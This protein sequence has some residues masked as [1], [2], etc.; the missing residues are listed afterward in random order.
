MTELGRLAF[1]EQQA[2]EAYDAMYEAQSPSHGCRTTSV[3]RPSAQTDRAA[4]VLIGHL[5]FLL[6]TIYLSTS[7]LVASP[8]STSALRHPLERCIVWPRKQPRSSW[9]GMA[10]PMQ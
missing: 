10:M 4:R 5:L 7:A 3:R 6:A 8:L 1:L 9:L 2:E